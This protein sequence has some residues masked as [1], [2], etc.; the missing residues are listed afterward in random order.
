MIAAA[1]LNGKNRKPTRVDM[2]ARSLRETRQCVDLNAAAKVD[3]LGGR[4]FAR[5]F[6]PLAGQ[7]WKEAVLRDQVAVREGVPRS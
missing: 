1:R 2:A 7:R 5:Q 4:R 6:R 3:L